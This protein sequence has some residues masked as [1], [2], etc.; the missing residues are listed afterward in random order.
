MKPVTGIVGLLNRKK[1]RLR[2]VNHGQSTILSNQSP[3]SGPVEFG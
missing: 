1:N 3:S 2:V